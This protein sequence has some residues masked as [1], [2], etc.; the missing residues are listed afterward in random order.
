MQDD[1]DFNPNQLIDSMKKLLG[2]EG[3]L[4]GANLDADEFSSDRK[5]IFSCMCSSVPMSA[6][7]HKYIMLND[8]IC[9]PA[10][11]HGQGEVLTK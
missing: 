6:L 10:T 8:I 9:K 5:M 3:N 1:V 7:D 4:G 11:T 2:E